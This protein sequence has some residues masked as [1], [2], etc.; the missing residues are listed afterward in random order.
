MGGRRGLSS[1]NGAAGLPSQGWHCL[2][3]VSEPLSQDSP[4]ALGTPAGSG[5]CLHKTFDSFKNFTLS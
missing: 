3:P 4:R 5:L 1:A 2:F